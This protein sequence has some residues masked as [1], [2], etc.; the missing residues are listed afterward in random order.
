MLEK[1]LAVFDA[2][3]EHNSSRATQE[4]LD[5]ELARIQLDGSVSIH[6]KNKKAEERVG[7]QK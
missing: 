4:K 2:L 1:Y 5:R 3:C 6:T 7:K